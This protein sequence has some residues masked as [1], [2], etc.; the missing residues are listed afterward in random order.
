V[1]ALIRPGRD[2]GGA[3]AFEVVR[4]SDGSTLARVIPDRGQLARGSFHELL[5]PTLADH[6]LTRQ[7]QWVVGWKL[8][9]G[10]QTLDWT[11]TGTGAP[12]AMTPVPGSMHLRVAMQEGTVVTLD[13]T[14][15][16]EVSRVR[17]DLPAVEPG[18]PRQIP[19]I[20]PWSLQNVAF[21]GDAQIVLKSEPGRIIRWDVRTGRK[22]KPV[23]I[24]QGPRAFAYMG[25]MVAGVVVVNK[26]GDRRSDLSIVRVPELTK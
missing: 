1:G 2:A 4:L 14:S 5:V 19:F 12:A 15:S 20:R 16:R 13:Y 26:S 17:L 23:S 22:L 25:S 21:S 18:A 6:L 8:P 24:I 10:E 3:F 9:T 7:D 11:W